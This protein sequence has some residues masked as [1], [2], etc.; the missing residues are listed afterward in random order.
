MGGDTTQGL[1]NAPRALIGTP[2]TKSYSLAQLEPSRT[3]AVFFLKRGV[4]TTK[5]A[6]YR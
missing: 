6:L 4:S 3:S 5:S 1:R 2:D